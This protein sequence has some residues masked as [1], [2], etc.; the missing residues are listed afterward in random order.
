MI[1]VAALILGAVLGMLVMAML[2]AAARENELRA[3][4]RRGWEDCSRAIA[5][6]VAALYQ[7]RATGGLLEAI[8][9]LDPENK[10]TALSPLLAALSSPE[11]FTDPETRPIR[12]ELEDRFAAV[13][14]QGVRESLDAYA[15]EYERVRDT[16]DPGDKRTLRMTTITAE[17]RAIAR[18]VPLTT[19]DLQNMLTS[20]RDGNGVIALAVLQDQPNPRLFP[21]VL[22]AIRESRSAFEQYQ[23][24]ATAFEMVPRLNKQQREQLRRA[25]EEALEDPERH[26]SDD[27]SRAK[28]VAAIL[29]ELEACTPVRPYAGQT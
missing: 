15:R 23:A 21:L 28:L 29:R 3:A 10:R 16:M 12:H 2:A 13:A 6:D 18:A 17:A 14:P 22:S 9:K 8:A 19:A 20:D 7:E 11:V 26:I 1:V 27:A 4:W 24:L 5:G 25:L